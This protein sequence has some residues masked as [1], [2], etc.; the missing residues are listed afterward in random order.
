MRLP[1]HIAIYFG[2][3]GNSKGARSNLRA[4]VFGTLHKWVFPGVF[5]RSVKEAFR[6]QGAEFHGASFCTIREADGFELDEKKSCSWTAGEPLACRLPYAV[7]TPMLSWEKTAKFWEMNRAKTPKIPSVSERSFQRRII[8][9]EKSCTFTVDGQEEDAA[10]KV[11][12]SDPN[13]EDMLDSGDA[14]WC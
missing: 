14:V 5:D 7:H 9:I 6:I 4:K 2:I 1:H 10:S 11:F 3:G 8:G 13:L 12:K